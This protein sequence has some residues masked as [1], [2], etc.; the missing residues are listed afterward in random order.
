MYR[1]I[2]PFAV[3]MAILTVCLCGFSLQADE[4]SDFITVPV[5]EVL[6]GDYKVVAENIELLGIVEGDAYVAG[7]QV[8]IDG[9]IKGDLLLA[10]G[11]ATVSGK[12]HGSIR[13]VGGE[14]TLSGNTLKNASVVTASLQIT[15]SALIKGNLS[16]LVGTVDL[17][18]TIEGVGSV[19]ASNVRVSGKV[20]HSLDVS[21]GRLRLTHRAVIGG[22]LNYQGNEEAAIDPTAIIRGKFTQHPTLLRK[23]FSNKFLHGLLVGTKFVALLMNFLFTFVVGAF[24]IRV[25]PRNLRATH[26]VL[27]HHPFKALGMGVVLLIALPLAS[28]VLLMTVLGA[29]FAVAILAIN[30]LGFYTA[31]IFTIT[32]LSN[33]A[34]NKMKLRLGPITVYAC[35]LLIYYVVTRLPVIGYFISLAALLFGLGAAILA[36]TKDGHII[37]EADEA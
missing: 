30:I 26:D 6:H 34:A 17:G 13:F 9:E 36:R 1:L 5:G 32:W 16:A 37:R 22:D 29:P 12:V 7:M 19:V 14:L 23:F 4:R 24:L 28:L 27:R 10:A 31:K 2:R 35:G 3:L 11:S 21:S 18:G 8:F 33:M 20:D 15:P 25:L